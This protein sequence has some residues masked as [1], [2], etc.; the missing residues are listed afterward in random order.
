MDVQR[1][2]EA[3][4]RHVRAKEVNIKLRA[5][6]LKKLIESHPKLYLD[7]KDTVYHIHIYIRGVV[8]NYREF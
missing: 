8:K 2:L 7:N 6:E 3:Y 1:L 5:L 4:R